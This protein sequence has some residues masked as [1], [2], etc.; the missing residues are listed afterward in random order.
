LREG[1]DVAVRIEEY[2]SCAGPDAFR[3]ISTFPDLTIA[4]TNGSASGTV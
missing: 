2:S 3:N 4:N 1:N